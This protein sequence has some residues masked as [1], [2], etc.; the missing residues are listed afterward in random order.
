MSRPPRR[1]P[2]RRRSRF[3]KLVPAAVL[4][5]V[6][7]VLTFTARQAPGIRVVADRLDDVLYDS[8]YHLRPPQDMR[9]ADTV[10]V[11]VDNESLRYGGQ[12]GAWPWRRE[13]WG[14]VVRFL[15]KQGARAIVFDLIF[16]EP[17]KWA[18]EGDDQAFADAVNA[19]QIPIVMGARVGDDGRFE[20]PVLP[21]RQSMLAGINVSDAAVYREYAQRIRGLNSLATEAAEKTEEKLPVV[22]DRFRL[23]YYGPSVR[24]DG[25]RTF[26][27]ISAAHVIAAAQPGATK[28]PEQLGLPADTFRGKTVLIG[29]IATGT[30]DEK[31]SPLDRSI[32]G[33]EIQATAIENLRRGQFVHPIGAN[34]TMGAMLLATF[35]AA[36]AT[37]VPRSV[38]LKLLFAALAAASLLAMAGALFSGQ[39][40]YWLRLAAPLTAVLLVTVGGLAWSYVTED[41][42][43]RQVLRQL[44]GYVS[45]AVAARVADD[46]RMLAPEKRDMTVMFTDIAG[47]TNISESLPSGRLAEM[48]N[49]YL[50]EMAGIILAQDGTI[51][52][53]IGDAVMS[54]WNAPLDQ[55]DHATAACRA[56]L[57]I[58][59]RE[60]Q[61]QAE[62][63]R[64]CGA[65]V[66]TRIGINSGSM[67][68]GDM[69]SQKKFNFT[70][71][72]DAVN[73]GSRLEGANKFY[74]SRII[75]SQ[76]TAEL[77]RGK[78]L[79]RQLDVLC[80][81]GKKQPIAVFELLAEG[82]G[83]AALHRR[84]ME[85]EAA[86]A[87][88]RAQRWDEAG[89]RLRALLADAPDDAPAAALLNRVTQLRADP[90]PAD[91]DGVY[92]AKTK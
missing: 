25:Q 63:A 77:V 58:V 89:D 73:L 57:A 91:W 80:V 47:F 43:R 46:P 14:H 23:H 81:S 78:F 13:Y 34:A 12:L 36:A 33:V 26:Q 27:Y 85:H 4:A 64:L 41:R 62:L 37:V 20:S 32:P 88:Y 51:D 87:H 53:F 90:P 65:P 75:L 69:G 42:L 60:R 82:E 16:T 35:L 19:C 79:V 84:A 50:G 31:A 72:G 10:I 70:V 8:L 74:G 17:S 56:A 45:P 86:F 28:T 30:Y 92:V 1:P 29:A 59:D 40:I 76:S 9:G 38:S 18:D 61:I 83:S 48:M 3:R 22:I 11:A 55:P 71:L 24:T 6:A 49:F 54:F 21:L 66:L 7:V 15:E 52:K 2:P 39:T 5:V 67:T 68:V 44:A